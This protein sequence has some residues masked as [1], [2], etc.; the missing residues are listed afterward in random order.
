MLR[1][2]EMGDDRRAPVVADRGR[3]AASSRFRAGTSVTLATT[4]RFA[5]GGELASLSLA[6]CCGGAADGGGDC[7]ALLAGGDRSAL[8]AGGDPQRVA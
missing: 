8:L 4:T 1:I 2:P 6:C 3:A 7:G 5:R